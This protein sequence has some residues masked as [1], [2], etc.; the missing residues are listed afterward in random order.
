MSIKIIWNF[1]K[2]R[3]QKSTLQKLFRILYS[4]EKKYKMNCLNGQYGVLD[5]IFTF[6]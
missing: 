5:R 1:V 3:L 2:Q 4:F 6:K